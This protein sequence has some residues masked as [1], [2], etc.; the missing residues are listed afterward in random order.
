MD[1]ASIVQTA[2][3]AV[4]ALFAVLIWMVTRR[5][6]N[7]TADLVTASKNQITL[8]REALRASLYEKRLNV[9]HAT[10]GFLAHFATSRL[11]KKADSAVTKNDPASSFYT[12]E[13]TINNKVESSATFR[14]SNVS[15]RIIR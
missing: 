3:A 5:Y 10:M 6:A 12:C 9:F 2:A 14:R 1:T 15:R 13:A 11:R 4:Q 7:L 8:Q